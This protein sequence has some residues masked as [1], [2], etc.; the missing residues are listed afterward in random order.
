LFTNSLSS[1][2]LRHYFGSV[3]PAGALKQ[4]S[5]QIDPEQAGLSIWICT[6]QLVSWPMMWLHLR[7]YA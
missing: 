3:S 7:F 6:H 4:A 1:T 2:E 5:G